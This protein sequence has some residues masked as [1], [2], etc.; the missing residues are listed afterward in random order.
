[1]KVFLGIYEKIEELCKEEF[2]SSLDIH[3]EFISDEN[4]EK[5]PALSIE[6]TNINPQQGSGTGEVY[7]STRWEIRI[8]VSS[9][10]ENYLTVTRDAC[11][12][13]ATILHDRSL[14]KN[15]MPAEFLGASDDNFDFKVKTFESWVSEFQI[16]LKVGEDLW[17]GDW[18]FLE[19]KS[20]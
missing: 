17:Q 19:V 13:I 1:M 12:R 7:L 2:G 8:L 4:L 9:K 15:S 11:A 14:S 16:D 5:L 20:V 10:Q 18:D 3:R 6:M